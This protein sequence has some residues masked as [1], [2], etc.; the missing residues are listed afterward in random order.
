MKLIIGVPLSAIRDL[1]VTDVTIKRAGFHVVDNVVG[2]VVARGCHEKTHMSTLW[3]Y[4][5]GRLA[6]LGYLKD[7]ALHCVHEPQDV[8]SEYIVKRPCQPEDRTRIIA[9]CKKLLVE[10]QGT[11]RHELPPNVVAGQRAIC[12]V[13]GIDL[14]W[15]CA[16]SPDGICHQNLET[17]DKLGKGINFFDGRGF[18]PLSDD[19]IEELLRWN[20][21]EEPSCLFCGEPTIR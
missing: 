16:E 10:L 2:M 5:E 6:A 3:S 17:H 1:G 9:L 19:R 7:A 15:T 18:F 14:G 12:A 21:S 11:C 8:L 20:Y 13:C 4:V